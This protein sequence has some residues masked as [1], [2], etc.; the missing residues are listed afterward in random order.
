MTAPRDARQPPVKTVPSWSWGPCSWWCWPEWAPWPW[1]TVPATQAQAAAKT[2]PTPRRLAGAAELVRSAATW[3]RPPGPPC[4]SGTKTWGNWTNAAVAV[5]N[6]DVAFYNG[7]RQSRPDRPT[8]WRSRPAAPRPGATRGT[9]L[10]GILGWNTQDLSATARA[11]LS[12]SDQTRCLKPFSPRPSSLE[13]PVRHQPQISRQRGLD[14]QSACEWPR[15]W[16]WASGDQDLGTPSCLR[17]ASA[18]TPWVPATSTP[19]TTPRSTAAPRRP[20]PMS[21][22]STSPAAPGPTTPRQRRG[23]AAERARNMVGPHQPGLDE[24]LAA[25]PDAALGRGHDDHHPQ[26]IRPIP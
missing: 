25:D 11:S 5:T 20:G 13:R 8:P 18:T 10:G 4:A 19:W 26:R 14:P 6:Q 22:G 1:I 24:L 21:T 12:S 7:R 23:R 3:P 16:S 2:P 15:W 17:S 9:A